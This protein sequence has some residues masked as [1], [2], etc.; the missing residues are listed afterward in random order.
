MEAIINAASQSSRIPCFRKDAAIGTVPYMQSGEAMP[1]IQAGIMPKAP[2]FVSF[3][4]AKMLW[5][6]P[7]AN[8]EI[9]AIHRINAYKISVLNIGFIFGG[10]G[11]VNAVCNDGL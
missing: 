11:N 2:H 4:P 3:M 5:I 7:F 9:N 6:L 10:D 1:R 8:T